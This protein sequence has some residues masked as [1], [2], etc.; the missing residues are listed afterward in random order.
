MIPPLKAIGRISGKHGFRGELNIELNHEQAAE[1]LKKG[2]FLFVDF[3]NKGV[4]FFIENIAG[5]GRILK[6]RDVDS[7]EMAMELS[8]RLIYL[9]KKLVPDSKQASFSG[10]KGFAVHDTLTDF[11]AIIIGIEEYPQGLMLIVESEGTHHLIPAI[12]EW[13]VEIDERKKII[14]MQLPD[15]LTEI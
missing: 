9:D 13:I 14:L 7:E 6:L 8:G 3:D 1:S 12:E 11:T 5:A 4:P 10:L 15:G 2:N